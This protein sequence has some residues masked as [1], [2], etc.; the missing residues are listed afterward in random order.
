[1]DI[2]IYYNVEIV[3]KFFNQWGIL[4][5]TF[6]IAWNQALLNCWL[7]L[8]AASCNVLAAAE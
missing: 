1:L 4:K 6:I 3:N 5:K 8:S 2:Y 7:K